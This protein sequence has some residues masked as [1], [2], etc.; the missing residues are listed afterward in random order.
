MENMLPAINNEVTQSR[1]DIFSDADAFQQALKVADVLS[2]S[3]IVP[4]HF[5]GES[6]KANCVVALNLAARLCA[7]VFMIMQNTTVIHGKPGF[8]GKLVIA[9]VNASGKFTPLRFRF[10]GEGKNRSCT[11]YARHISSGGDEYEQT[12]SWHTV[13]AEGWANKAGSKW[14]TIPDLMFQYRS[15]TWFARVFCPEVLLGMQT[16]D[17]LHDIKPSRPE[18]ISSHDT[19]ESINVPD[20]APV[21]NPYDI[22]FRR[23]KEENIDIKYLADYIRHRAETTGRDINV[24]AGIMIE[25]YDQFKKKFSEWAGQHQEDNIIDEIPEREPGEEG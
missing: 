2:K 11:A 19:T 14:K 20:T 4:E 6:G 22:L 18:L 25:N 8:E 12:V 5:R 21:K 15:A 17:E 10:E 16:T 24:L 23:A 7:D 3:S 1:R 13:E 9:L